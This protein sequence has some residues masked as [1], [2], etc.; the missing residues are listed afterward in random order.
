MS[1]KAIEW[2]LWHV[3][4][5]L[6]KLKDNRFTGNIEYRFNIKG[7]SIANMNNH[8]HKSIKMPEGK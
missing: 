6:I 5:E 2:Y 1:D 4:E 7:G 8:L 3:R